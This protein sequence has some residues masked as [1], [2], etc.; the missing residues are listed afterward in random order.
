[1]CSIQTVRVILLL[2]AMFFSL[3]DTATAGSE[4]DTLGQGHERY[5]NSYSVPTAMLARVLS[6]GS[7][8]VFAT[9]AH[10]SNIV[11]LGSV[12]PEKF[13]SR[14][15]G[16]VEIDQ[17]GR[18]MQEAAAESVNIILVIGD[19]MGMGQLSLPILMRRARK[20]HGPTWLEKILSH[21][22]TGLVMT[23]MANEVITD[24][25]A[26]GTA[27]ATGHRTSPRRIGTDHSG[28]HLESVLDLAERMGFRTGLVTDTR[29]THATPA[30]FYGHADD[31]A[32][33]AEIAA[34]LV[35]RGDIDVIFGGGAGFFIPRD[36]RVSDHP[37]LAKIRSGTTT[38]SKRKDDRDLIAELEQKG[39]TLVTTE[40]EL[41]QL[42]PTTEKALGL[43]AGN[44]MNAAIDRDEED[45]SE[46]SIPQMTDKAI[47]LLSRDNARFLLMVECGRI[48]WESHGNDAG[49]LVKAM[50][51][52]DA[53][54]GVAWDRWQK[55]P[56]N[57]L[58]LFTADHDNGGFSFAYAYRTASIDYLPFTRLRLLDRQKKSL[59]A[60]LRASH[61]STE[62]MRQIKQN[63]AWTITLPQ[64]E[65]VMRAK[66]LHWSA[67]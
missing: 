26:A 8:A 7:Q 42:A 16:V 48:D 36:S 15:K 38:H 45:T 51:E 43:F 35:K 4:Q 39:Y 21:G 29:I 14:L 5:W 28:K 27:L 17:V 11:A 23:H 46:P 61:T 58:L 9:G 25:A 13:T 32:Q 49:A 64:A 33:E 22:A 53:T 10:S 54:L 31:R 57:T 65:A 2:A 24:S 66:Q 18:V 1:M 12:G 30:V 34:Q 20:G 67:Q 44:G 50:D 52:M 62:L 60:M 37:S 63:T 55:D 3:Q 19:G 41:Q 6:A 59:A 40:G 56:A 47:A